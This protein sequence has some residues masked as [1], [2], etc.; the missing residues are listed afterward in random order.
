MDE[1]QD[2]SRMLTLSRKVTERGREDGG[3]R[4]REP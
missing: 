2:I 1:Q 3:S 4:E